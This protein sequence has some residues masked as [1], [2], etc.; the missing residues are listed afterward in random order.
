MSASLIYVRGVML[1]AAPIDL[2]PVSERVARHVTSVSGGS[3]WL[4]L[5]GTP[6]DVEHEL[7]KMGPRFDVK[8]RGFVV[9][10]P[11]GKAVKQ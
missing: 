9:E 7:V 2:P 5:I 11:E 1:G 10:V 8:A 6:T 4:S 3:T